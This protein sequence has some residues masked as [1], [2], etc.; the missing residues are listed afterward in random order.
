MSITDLFLLFFNVWLMVSNC[1]VASDSKHSLPD[2]LSDVLADLI[3]E[4]VEKRFD[5]FVKSHVD[6]VVEQRINE[7]VDRRLE[8]MEDDI[9]D[10]VEER[11]G[12]ITRQR[13]DEIMNDNVDDQIDAKLHDIAEQLNTDS[14]SEDDNNVSRFVNYMLLCTLMRFVIEMTM[15][16]F[17]LVISCRVKFPITLCLNTIN[18]GFPKWLHKYLL[19]LL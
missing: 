9:N 17:L 7:L 6:N 11:V 1:V 18:D 19:L 16:S 12:E 15:N 5:D 13:I 8:E 2:G 4:A 10:R 3:D 14:T